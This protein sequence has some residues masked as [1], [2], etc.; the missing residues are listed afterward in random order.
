MEA[1]KRW[2]C[3]ALTV[4]KDCLYLIVRAT[5]SQVLGTSRTLCD[6]NTYRLWS[7]SVVLTCSLLVLI[8]AKCRLSHTQQ[9][10]APLFLLIDIQLV[11][12][13]L[14]GLGRCHWLQQQPDVVCYSL[15][16]S[17]RMLGACGSTCMC[18]EVVPAIA[19]RCI[20]PY[21]SSHRSKKAQ[22]FSEGGMNISHF[23]Y[24]RM[25]VLYIM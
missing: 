19:W 18:R 13:W 10:R 3:W 6:R 2:L 7:A 15:W 5:T 12:R 25:V 16:P 22:I 11:L 23:S 14:G 20:A 21:T 4:L 8:R 9:I 1:M 17:A 24:N